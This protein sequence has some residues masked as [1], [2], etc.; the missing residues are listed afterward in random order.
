MR[1]LF[2]HEQGPCRSTSTHLHELL[3]SEALTA[4]IVLLEGVGD[5]RLDA[6]ISATPGGRL[7][8]GLAWGAGRVLHLK[9]AALE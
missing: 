7:Q 3:L 2:R 6:L 4:L 8:L 1:I 9:T 5:A